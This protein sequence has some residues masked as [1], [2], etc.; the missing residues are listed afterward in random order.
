MSTF[1]TPTNPSEEMWL[2]IA[3]TSVV[4][5]VLAGLSH[6]SIF[7]TLGNEQ[8]PLLNEQGFYNVVPLW[9]TLDNAFQGIKI[10]SKLFPIC[11]G[12]YYFGDAFTAKFNT[13]SGDN[14]PEYIV[15]GILTLA[16]FPLAIVIYCVQAA[17]LVFNALNYT[18]AST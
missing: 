14:S 17:H 16:V 13:N 2:T 4:G 5:L 1:V 12:L 10:A 11:Y 7:A 6:V 8:D 3:A 18:D 9:L 15:D